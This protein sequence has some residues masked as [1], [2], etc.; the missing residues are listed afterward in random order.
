MLFQVSMRLVAVCISLCILPS[1]LAADAEA[2]KALFPVCVACHGPTG[3][4]SQAMNGPKLAGQEAWYL[5]RQMQ[6]FQTGA[7]GTASGDASGM[8]MAAMAKGPQLATEEALDNLAAY[9]TTLPNEPSAPTVTGDAVAGKSQFALCAA[10]HGAKGEG[11]AAMNGPRLA[12]QND[13][14]LVAQIKKYQQ[15]QRG[16]HASDT[17]G[18]QMR[19]MVASLTTDEAI[20]NV[21]AYINSLQ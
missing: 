10:C 14:Y 18:A 1:A 17:A 9:I 2:G 4:G 8:Q 5:K 20:N 3:Q 7:R 19:P 12:G 21:V 6:L 15:G 13:W 11:V 16:Y